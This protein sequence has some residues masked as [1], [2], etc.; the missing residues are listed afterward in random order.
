[1]H[2]QYSKIVVVVV[3]YISSHPTTPKK[4][5]LFVAL[6]SPSN[7]QRSISPPPDIDIGVDSTP[8]PESSGMFLLISNVLPESNTGFVD[9]VMHVKQAIS[10]ILSCD[11]GKGLTEISVEVIAGGQSQDTHASLEFLE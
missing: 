5:C 8:L 9:P 7:H 11:E 2:H 6:V 1:L 3:V 4:L 10:E